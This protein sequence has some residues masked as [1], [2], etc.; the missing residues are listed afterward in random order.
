[1]TN[2]IYDAIRNNK[3]LVGGIAG[4]ALT[5]GG[6][7]KSLDVAGKNYSTEGVKNVQRV[8]QIGHE[9]DNSIFSGMN[10]TLRDFANTPYYSRLDSLGEVASRLVAERDSLMGLLDY[11]AQVARRNS[12]VLSGVG[13][14]FGSM[15]LGAFSL[16]SIS[17]G[18]KRIGT[19]RL[20]RKAQE[21]KI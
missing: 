17:K 6:C 3:F 21:E 15:V 4:M 1:M 9:L 16:A 8:E 2:P 14:F 10:L 11:N 7:A 20:E 5:Y 18:F 13:L 19:R 12:D